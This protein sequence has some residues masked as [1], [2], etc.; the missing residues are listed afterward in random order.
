MDENKVVQ[1]RASCQRMGQTDECQDI[2]IFYLFINQ[3]VICS[4]PSF[5][6]SRYEQ[7]LSM[8]ETNAMIVEMCLDAL[9]IA[10]KVE[11]D[12]QKQ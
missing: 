4:N 3:K 5:S 9:G 7:L 6:P 11:T 12:F 10:N 2:H 8:Y 1:I